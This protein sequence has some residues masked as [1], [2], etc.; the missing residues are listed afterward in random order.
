M[1]EFDSSKS[2]LSNL[3]AKYCVGGIGGI[4]QAVTK[5]TDSIKA[6]KFEGKE[7]FISCKTWIKD[8]SDSEEDSKEKQAEVKECKW[9]IDHK[10]DEGIMALAEVKKLNTIGEITICA[11][12]YI[13]YDPNN[14]KKHESG[15][16]MC[17]TDEN[18]CPS[19]EVC[20]AR[21]KEFK[22]LSN[23]GI[24]SKPTNKRPA[25]RSTRQ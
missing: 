22:K 24:Y 15:F 4:H 19:V 21:D 3:L 1:D 13:C 23:E 12:D 11:G 7:T 2:T 6:V 5:E 18:D 9:L 16:L 25:R 14:Y 20:K 10:P 17:E 8:L